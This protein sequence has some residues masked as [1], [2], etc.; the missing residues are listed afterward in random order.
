MLFLFYKIKVMQEVHIN[1][2]TAVCQIKKTQIHTKK[3]FWNS[4]NYLFKNNRCPLQNGVQ[5]HLI[6]REVPHSSA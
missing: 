6:S 5:F 3:I 2:E 1:C 4:F